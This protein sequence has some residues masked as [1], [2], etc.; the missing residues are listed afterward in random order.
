[1]SGLNS[2]HNSFLLEMATDLSHVLVKVCSFRNCV[3]N[4]TNRNICNHNHLCR[5]QIIAVA[6][7]MINKAT[8][9][10]TPEMMSATEK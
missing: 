5:K 3:V 6:P 2:L 1:M 8:E 4:H 9:P 7:M 10:P